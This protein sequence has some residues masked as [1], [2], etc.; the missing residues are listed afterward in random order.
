MTRLM[1]HLPTY[2]VGRPSGGEVLATRVFRVREPGSEEPV[3]FEH[4]TGW[5]TGEV[6]HDR[7]SPSSDPTE[8]LKC[9]VGADSFERLAELNG[10]FAAVVHDRRERMVHLITNRHGHE[11][12][13][14]MRREGQL[15]WASEAKAMLGV[16]GFEPQIDRLSAESFMQTGMLLGDRSWFEGVKLV[17]PGSVLSFAPASGTIHIRRYWHWN[18]AAVRSSS[19]SIPH[20]A[21][22]LG[23]RFAGAVHARAPDSDRIGLMLSGGLD[24]RAILGAASSSGR[25]IPVVTYGKAESSDVRVA[26]RVA[27][28]RNAD[29]YFF[30][31]G[32]EDWLSPRFP[33]LWR[34]D[35]EIGLLHMHL[36]VAIDR[37]SDLY[38]VELQGFAGDLL[39]GGS[40]LRDTRYLKPEGRLPHF[41]SEVFKCDEKL[42][43]QLDLPLDY[44]RTDHFFLETWVRRFTL[45]GIR[46]I[47]SVV[48]TRLPFF[49]ND[50]L[51][52]AYS[53]PDSFRYGGALYR[54]MLLDQL[55]DLYRKIPY[56]ATGKPIRKPVLT[57]LPVLAVEAGRTVDRLRRGAR[58]R[59]GPPR[60]HRDYHDYPAWIRV[61]PVVDTITDLLTDP[62]AMYPDFVDRMR[63]RDRLERHINGENHAVFLLRVVTME[64]WLRQIFRREYRPDP[65][66]DTINFRQAE[67]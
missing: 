33:L 35:G 2:R 40:Y 25:R 51:D 23:E 62:D 56:A 32:A 12:L 15:Y 30:E 24:S 59:V 34:I 47:R 13:Y 22:E 31:L 18:E 36:Q 45:S 16:P 5:M 37:L 63:V 46:L 66:V 61:R 10:A 42:L 17:P 39:L 27:E 44:T 7:R 64:I 43:E 55:P 58:R 48:R 41:A 50:L 52:F 21:K 29:F 57:S 9:L 28:A 3:I 54:H 6:V 65:A 14:W 4:L 20:A 19:I 38:E 49:D 53:L 8:I 60:R 67:D 11:P 1:M 26:R